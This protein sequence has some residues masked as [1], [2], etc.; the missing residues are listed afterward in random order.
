VA[1]DQ[2]PDGFFVV[3][4]SGIMGLAFAALSSTRSTPFWQALG[5]Q[6]AAPEMAFYLTRFKDDFRAQQ[7]EPGGVFTLGGVESTL[8]TGNI[9]FLAMPS[10]TPTHYWS[11]TMSGK[12]HMKTCKLS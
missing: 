12:C 8:F 2:F 11:L 3:S 7:E 9:E 10:S 5:S 4:A 6:L 1:V